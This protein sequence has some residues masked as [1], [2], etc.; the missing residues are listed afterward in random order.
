MWYVIHMQLNRRNW[1]P[2]LFKQSASFPEM[3]F[4]TNA[5]SKIKFN[6]KWRTCGRSHSTDPIKHLFTC[7]TSL[8]PLI[9]AH[10]NEPHTSLL[11]ARDGRRRRRCRSHYEE[12]NFDKYQFRQLLPSWVAVA[13]SSCFV[14]VEVLEDPERGTDPAVLVPYIYTPQTAQQQSA[15]KKVKTQR[16]LSTSVMISDYNRK[17]NNELYLA[18]VVFHGAYCRMAII[19]PVNWSK[20]HVP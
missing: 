1:F 17:K 18:V 20:P 7:W 2:N 11:H 6:E 14:A 8:C 15:A 3:N 13:R 5:V 4:S 12:D 19:P 9:R 16:S 10:R